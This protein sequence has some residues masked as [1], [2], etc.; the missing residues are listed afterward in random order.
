MAFELTC[1][2]VALEETMEQAR[3]HLARVHGLAGE[4]DL[5]KP[6]LG[7]MKAAAETQRALPDQIAKLPPDQRG[8]VLHGHR[9]QP[10]R[11]RAVGVVSRAPDSADHFPGAP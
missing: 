3:A 9:L 7:S 4:R 11:A 8:R 2:V 10:A 5:R 6:V 1:I